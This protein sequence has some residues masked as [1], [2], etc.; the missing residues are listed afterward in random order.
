MDIDKIIIEVLS[1]KP[2]PKFT[3]GLNIDIN[4]DINQ[5]YEIL[6]LMFLRS[7][8]EKIMK[9]SDIKDIKE[10]KKD[11][12]RQFFI[13]KLYLNSCGVDFKYSNIEKKNCINYKLSNSPIF[14]SKNKYN[15]LFCIVQNIYRKGRKFESYYNMKKINSFNELFIIIK[16]K[17][18]FFKIELELLKK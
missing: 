4:T 3:Y 1:D 10:L 7:V 13:I 8:E 11:I 14:Y 6:T 16:I 9:I 17:N 18:H 15:S 2:K 5:Q 12:L